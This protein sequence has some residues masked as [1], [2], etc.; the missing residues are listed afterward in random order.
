[1]PTAYIER[2]HAST[3]AVEFGL[4]DKSRAG[5]QR[6]CGESGQCRGGVDVTSSG[7]EHPGK[8]LHSPR[9]HALHGAHQGLGSRFRTLASAPSRISSTAVGR[10]VGGGGCISPGLRKRACSGFLLSVDANQAGSNLA[11][12]TTNQF[13]SNKNRTNSTQL[14]SNHTSGDPGRPQCRIGRPSRK[15]GDIAT[16]HVEVSL[17]AGR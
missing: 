12:S 8:S 2:Q 14:K 13:K 16:A 7:L 9:H 15:R 1:M 11:K 6:S 3:L 17:R 5:R 4:G 10:A